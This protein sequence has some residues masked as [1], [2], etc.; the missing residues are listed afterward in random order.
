MLFVYG[1]YCLPYR[2]KIQ[3]NER[4]LNSPNC[5]YICGMK[6][7]GTILIIVLLISSCKTSRDQ[8]IFTELMC[9]CSEPIVEWRNHLQADPASLS[10]GG[11]L[12]KELRECLQP[13]KERFAPYVTDTAF[14]Y[15]LATEINQKCPESNTVVNAMLLIL[16]GEE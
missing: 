4:C 8:E 6:K 7:Y 16:A 13:E 11:Q 10:Q 15:D 9:E 2:V 14:I 12:E 5:T 3:G 1:D